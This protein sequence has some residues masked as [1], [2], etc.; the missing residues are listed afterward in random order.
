MPKSNFE[1][2]DEVLVRG[3]VTAV[4]P[5]GQ[6]TVQIAWAAHKVTMP[7]GN[8]NIMPA[9]GGPLKPSDKPRRLV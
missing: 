4:W 8:G 2:G 3:V 5:D 6:V 1:V 9:D 7:G